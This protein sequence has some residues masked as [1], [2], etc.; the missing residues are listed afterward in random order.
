V[1][2]FRITTSGRNGKSGRSYPAWLEWPRHLVPYRFRAV[3]RWWAN[4]AGFFWTPCPLCG[5]P[6]GG[7]EWRDVNGKVSTV[8]NPMKPPVK[9]G[10]YASTSSIG[11]CPVCTEAGR[12]VDQTLPT[13]DT[14]ETP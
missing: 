13:T 4:L 5:Q 9:R 11:I 7:H 14:D 6:F 1:S 10:P 2:E 3:H 12:G 8:P